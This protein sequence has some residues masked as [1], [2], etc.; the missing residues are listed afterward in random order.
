MSNWDWDFGNKGNRATTKKT[1][2][3]KKELNEMIVSDCFRVLPKNKNAGNQWN[4]SFF[5]CVEQLRGPLRGKTGQRRIKHIK[6]SYAIGP[7][8]RCVYESNGK[9]IR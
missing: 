6:S 1:S 9:A 7:T 4:H 8:F 5:V 3:S 2:F